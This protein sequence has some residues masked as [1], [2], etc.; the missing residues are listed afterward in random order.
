MDSAVGWL[1]C[2]QR[3]ILLALSNHPAVGTVLAHTGRR[4]HASDIEIM[5]C[6]DSPF[7][8]AHLLDNDPSER[9]CSFAP[10]SS[11][12]QRPLDIAQAAGHG[13]AFPVLEHDD[14]LALEHRLQ[15]LHPVQVYDR[16]AANAKK[17]FRIK[18]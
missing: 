13:E 16:A 9:V 7:L 12:P 10:F 11:K 17:L 2:F 4:N 6:G 1:I 14:M 18:L 5:P 15:F 8:R 3:S